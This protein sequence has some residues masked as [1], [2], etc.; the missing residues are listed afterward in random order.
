ML[1]QP[2]TYS[3]LHRA[4]AD[5]NKVCKQ[6]RDHVCSFRYDPKMVFVLLLNT[7]QFEF[8]LKEVLTYI[9]NN[10]LEEEL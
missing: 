1:L 8:I 3:C 10:G 5:Y 6:V 9:I 7:A 4:V 2:F